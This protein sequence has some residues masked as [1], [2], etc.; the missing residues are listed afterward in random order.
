MNVKYTAII[1][2]KF[3]INSF[4]DDIL[5]CK[6]ENLQT[7]LKGV[8]P[9]AKL[10]RSKLVSVENN[11]ATAEYEFHHLTEEKSY[12]YICPVRYQLNLDPAQH[13]YKPLVKRYHTGPSLEP[14]IN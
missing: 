2:Y 9:S 13:G 5:K 12:A 4:E 14:Y 3:I 7:L 11:I 10:Y 6:P 1:A 8:H